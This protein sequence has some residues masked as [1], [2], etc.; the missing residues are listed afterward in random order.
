MTTPPIADWPGTL[1]GPETRFDPDS[2]PAA[3]SAMQY[4]RGANSTLHQ[5][6]ITWLENAERDTDDHGL[7]I[8]SS[9][10]DLTLSTGDEDEQGQAL[11]QPAEISRLQRPGFI[12]GT[13]SDREPSDQLRLMESLGQHPHFASPKELLACAR[14]LRPGN[15]HLHVGDDPERDRAMALGTAAEPTSHR[16]STPAPP[17]G[18]TSCGPAEGTA[19]RAET[20][21]SIQP[22]YHGAS[23]PPQ[24]LH[25]LPV[26]GIRKLPPPQRLQILGSAGQ[27]DHG[28]G[29]E[30]PQ[31]QAALLRPRGTGTARRGPC[32][33]NLHMPADPLRTTALHRKW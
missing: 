27:Q 28:R 17:G 15:L 29:V 20:V 30:L 24:C 2:H 14:R 5:V 22:R 7:S 32:K 18:P 3:A 1:E 25:H 21:G 33:R 6:L 13:C 9:D 23:V 16:R 19:K 4:P 31:E 8:L 10:I 26:G 11:I 12:V